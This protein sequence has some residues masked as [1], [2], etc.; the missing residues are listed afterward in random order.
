MRPTED[1][2]K[3]PSLQMMENPKPATSSNKV[4]PGGAPADGSSNKGA[5]EDIHKGFVENKPLLD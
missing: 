3:K 4:N 5:N 1:D 2:D